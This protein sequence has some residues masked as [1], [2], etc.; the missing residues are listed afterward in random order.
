MYVLGWY[1][2]TDLS[3]ESLLFHINFENEELGSVTSINF[4]P[5]HID[6]HSIEGIL[7]SSELTLD[8]K[9]LPFRAIRKD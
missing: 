8:N 9:P 2:I 1:P 3:T 4:H 6:E 5:D 7:Y